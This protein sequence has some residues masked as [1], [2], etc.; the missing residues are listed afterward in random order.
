[1]AQA[2]AGYVVVYT[3]T[4]STIARPPAKR[5]VA[6]AL[7]NAFGQLGNVAGAYVWPKT[8]GPSYKN[9]FGICVANFGVT[10]ILGLAFRFQLKRLN[11][12]LDREE[13]LDKLDEEAL[14]QT[15]RLEGVSKEEV[16]RA[17]KGWRYVY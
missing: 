3:W 13:G 10:I 12:K 1:M 2:Y 16:L 4:S 9:S 15:A 14:E 6:L 17:R 5:A 8:W 11:R 7:V